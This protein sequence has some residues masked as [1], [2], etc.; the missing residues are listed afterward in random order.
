MLKQTK[1]QQGDEQGVTVSKPVRRQ[2]RNKDQQI[3]NPVV[4]PQGSQKQCRCVL[5]AIKYAFDLGYFRRCP[6]DARVADYNRAPCRRPDRKVGA[7]IPGVIK[8][9][10]PEASDQKSGL[11]FAF[12]VVFTVAGQHLGEQ[13]KVCGACLG[14]TYVCCRDQNDWATLSLLGR[15]PVNKRVVQ[16]QGRY[17]QH[18]SRSDPCLEI[19]P[20][21]Q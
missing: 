19:G 6:L 17:I 11:R 12:Q 16:R 10:A 1:G 14:D 3:L 5:I 8:T 4:R 21:P 15:N 18:L 2:K 20:P 7:R 9:A 13:S